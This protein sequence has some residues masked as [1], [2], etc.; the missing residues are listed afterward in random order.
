MSPVTQPSMP[1]ESRANGVGVGSATSGCAVVESAASV[2]QALAV[3]TAGQQARDVF[4][5]QRL[6]SFQRRVLESWAIGK[7]SFVLSGTGS[8]KSGCFVL[9]TLVDR[10][11]HQ[12][13]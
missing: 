1:D 3:Q 5:W 13:A 7:N 11:W 12:Q 8:G 10:C 2:I 9:P 6:R 4:G